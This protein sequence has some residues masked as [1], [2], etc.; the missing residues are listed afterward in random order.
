MNSKE[1]DILNNCLTQSSQVLN[2]FKNPQ[3]LKKLL[4]LI[5]LK[6]P[7][8]NVILSLLSS[9]HVKVPKEVNRN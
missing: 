6:K 2:D 1:L 7:L 9:K 4:T 5:P 3:L 8:R